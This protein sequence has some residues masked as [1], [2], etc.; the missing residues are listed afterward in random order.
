MIYPHETIEFL[1]GLDPYYFLYVAK[2]NLENLK[3]EYPHYAAL[4]IRLTYFHA[5]E[6]FFSLL[7]ATLQAPDC[8]HGWLLRYTNRSLR[9]LV[10]EFDNGANFK[11]KCALPANFTWL[12]ISSLIYSCNVKEEVSQ[13]KIIAFA[14]FWH[15]ISKDF[16]NNEKN[17]EYNSIKHGFRVRPGGFSVN[18]EIE[19]LD[20]K[21]AIPLIDNM[22]G[23]TFF[24]SRNLSDDGIHFKLAKWSVNWNPHTLAHRINYLAMSIHNLIS[25]LNYIHKS[26][27]LS[28]FHLPQSVSQFESCW[29]EKN[30]CSY[31][32]EPEITQKQIVNFSSHEILNVYD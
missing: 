13:E 14:E 20:K 24:K 6:S 4:S 16:I 31:V 7:C 8:V 18:M 23:T 22:Y 19:Y 27:H 12:D 10:S 3:S 5:M 32:I 26:P 9:E 2:I 15:R 21:K 11:N 28:S 1:Q 17:V 29:N 30:A 25:F